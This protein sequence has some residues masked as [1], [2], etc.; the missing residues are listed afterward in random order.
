V[1]RHTDSTPGLT[2]R[3]VLTVGVLGAVTAAAAACTRPTSSTR[4]AQNL[5]TGADLVFGA[6]LELT[7]SGAVAGTAQQRALKIAE[8]ALNTNGVTVG[9]TVRQVRVTVRDNRSDPRTA[10]GIVQEFVSGKVAGII[11][12]GL[13]TT[14]IAMAG[15]AEP[16]GVPMVSTCAADSVVAPAPNRRFVFKLGPNADDVARLMRGA[17]D[18]DGTTVTRV[19]LLAQAG[20]HGEAGVQAIKKVLAADGRKLVALERLADGADYRGPAGRVIAASP[21]AVVIWAVSPVSGA[22]ARALRAGGYSRRMLFDTG[23]ASD[24]SLS[25]GNR[26][27]MADSYVVAPQILGGSS[28]AANTP[29]GLAQQDFFERYSRAY[30]GFSCLGVYAA[31]A[32]NLLAEAAGRAGAAT[33]LRIRNELEA[34]PFDGLAG[35]YV[36]STASHGGIQPEGLALFLLERNGS[37]LTLS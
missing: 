14:S 20:D 32:V 29:I 13:A 21:E 4:A 11:G 16:H 36:F 10:A 31:D 27:A 9:G 2:R 6:S 1:V 22:A 15:V 17:F 19:A 5:P 12:G 33:P 37:W 8:D 35:A 26:A 7:G 3:S 24:D 18:R 23:A 30:G 28:V 25:P 34:S